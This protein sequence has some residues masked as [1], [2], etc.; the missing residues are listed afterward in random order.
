M[1]PALHDWCHQLDSRRSI[2]YKANIQSHLKQ[3]VVGAEI[4]NCDYMKHLDDR[5]W[6]FRV[7][8]ERR[9]DNTRIFGAFVAL[10][11]FIAI[12]QELRSKIDWSKDVGKTLDKVSEFVSPHRLP[13]PVPFSNCLTKGYDCFKEASK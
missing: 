2:D 10:N 6:E 4:D 7:Q 11:T 12:R 1:T 8:L 5:I 9:K 3:F 13:N